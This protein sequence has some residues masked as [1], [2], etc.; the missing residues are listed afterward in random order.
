MQPKTGFRKLTGA[1][2][3]MTD[4]EKLDCFV[5]L[6]GQMKKDRPLLEEA[7]NIVERAYH[8]MSEIESWLE[9][10]FTNKPDLTP[11][12]VIPECISCMKLNAG[13]EPVLW[14]LARKVKARVRARLQAKEKNHG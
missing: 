2:P 9:A 6:I 1:I 3:F 5:V 4:K 14:L 11:S 13:I 8:P 12:R 7:L 10:R